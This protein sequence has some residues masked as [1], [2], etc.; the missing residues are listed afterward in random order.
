MKFPLPL[1]TAAHRLLDRPSRTGTLTLGLGLSVAVVGLLALSYPSVA[2]R[3]RNSEMLAERRAEVLLALLSAAMDRDMKAV[4]VSVLL[5][6][7]PPDPVANPPT[8]LRDLVARTFVRFP[9]PESFFLWGGTA[10]EVTAFYVFNRADRPPPW[11]RQPGPVAA[12]PAVVWRNPVGARPL[13]DAVKQHA[14]GTSR[15]VVFECA[16]GGEPYQVI[17]KRASKDGDASTIVGFTVN[18]AWAR[19]HYFNELAASVLRVRNEAEAASIAFHDESGRRVAS[20]GWLGARGPVLERQF[21]PVFFDPRLSSAAP[22]GTEPNRLWTAR[23]EAAP[24]LT[25]FGAGLSVGGLYLMLAATAVASVLGMLFTTRRVMANAALA[26]QRSEFISTVTHE[27]KTRLASIRLL[28]E[29]LGDGRYGSVDA[30]RDYAGLLSRE[31]WR[32]TRLIDNLLAYA[33]ISSSRTPSTELHEV[34]ELLDEVVAH[35]RPQLV[36]QKFVVTVDIPPDLPRVRGDRTALLHALDNLV[37]NAIKY[38]AGTRE[39]TIRAWA[40]NGH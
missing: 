23:V 3:H 27:L 12:F 15:D 14:A 24:E 38:S 28:A 11:D 8:D 18:L 7:A 39:L 33:S 35:F 29:T 5:P 21:S 22:A 36:D 30:I 6:F 17:A 9:Y 31:A 16:L 19:K 25:T 2:D 10:R 20:A 13:I 26:E 34:A 40:E 4:Q 1:P 37:D 32:L